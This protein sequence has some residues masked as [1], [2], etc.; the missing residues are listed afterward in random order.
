MAEEKKDQGWA[1]EDFFEL[2]DEVK[3]RALF[4]GVLYVWEAVAKIGPYVQEFLEREVR[5]NPNR[6]S[7]PDSISAHATIEGMIHMGKGSRIL[8]GTHILGDTYIGED[9]TIGPNAT[10]LGNNIIGDGC[11]IRPNA[12]LRGNAIIGDHS[13]VGCEVKNAYFMEAHKPPTGHWQHTSAAHF[14]YV[15]DSILGRSVNLGAGTKLSNVKVFWTAITPEVPDAPP[16]GF[17]LGCIL[18]DFA[19][20]ACNVVTAPGTLIGKHSRVLVNAKG[21]IPAYVIVKQG[22]MIPI[23]SS[24]VGETLEGR[25]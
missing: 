16:A 21:A 2:T 13:V 17:K 4:E 10:L 19:Q 25:V 20:T 14:S 12:V 5:A 22:G 3:H 18:G 15:G 11:E 8:P 9:T 6:N 23:D 24:R 1:P 7:D